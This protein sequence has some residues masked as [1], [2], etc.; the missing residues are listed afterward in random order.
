[1]KNNHLVRL[2]HLTDPTL[3]IGGFTHSMGLETYVQNGQVHDIHSAE[4]FIVQMLSENLLY[5]DASFL[6]LA[7]N[8]ANDLPELLKLDEECSAYKIPRETKEASRKLGL[9]LI[10]LLEDELHTET[11]IQFIQ[12]VNQKLTD[13]NYCIV[14][15]LFSALMKI[16]KADALTGYYYNQVVSMV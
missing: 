14:F 7:Y 13:S 16:D 8:A 12:H 9:R 2:L 5:N 10:R 3:P 6:S 4:E 1:M 11:S 15:G